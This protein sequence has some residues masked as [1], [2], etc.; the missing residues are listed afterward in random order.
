MMKVDW[1]NNS[2][3]TEANFNEYCKTYLKNLPEHYY[4]QDVTAGEGE[5]SVKV[6]IITD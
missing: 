2:M 1:Q 5:G 3:I 6:R 4:G